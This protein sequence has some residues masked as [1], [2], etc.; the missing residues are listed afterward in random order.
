MQE[1]QISSGCWN[2]LAES[3]NS[4]AKRVVLHEIYKVLDGDGKFLINGSKGVMLS[5]ESKG[6]FERRA[7][8]GGWYIAP[9]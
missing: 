2:A 6:E 5:C 7:L 1:F 4:D 9:L 8:E 3:G